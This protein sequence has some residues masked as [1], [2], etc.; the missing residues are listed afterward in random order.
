[1]RRIATLVVG[2]LAFKVQVLMYMMG[3]G[4]VVS[5]GGEEGSP[6]TYVLMVPAVIM[7]RKPVSGKKLTKILAMVT[8]G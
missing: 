1:M 4:R 7:T 5:R 6:E 3:R 8:I 2:V